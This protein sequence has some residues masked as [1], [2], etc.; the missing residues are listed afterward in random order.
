MCDNLTK[1]EGEA[2]RVLIHILC[3]GELGQVLIQLKTTM[4]EYGGR[5]STASA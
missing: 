2:L 3:C 5:R 1:Q 4:L